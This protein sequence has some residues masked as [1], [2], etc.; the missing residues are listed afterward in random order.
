[1]CTQVWIDPAAYC[2]RVRKSIWTLHLL[3]FSKWY[4]KPDSLLLHISNCWKNDQFSRARF[5]RWEFPLRNWTLCVLLSQVPKA[6]GKVE[7]NVILLSTCDLQLLSLCVPHPHL[8]LRIR[9]ACRV[10]CFYVDV[11]LKI[12]ENLDNKVYIRRRHQVLGRCVSWQYDNSDHFGIL[13]EIGTLGTIQ[14]SNWTTLLVTR[15][16]KLCSL[17]TIFTR[18]F[19]FRLSEGILILVV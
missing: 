17:G 18:K 14:C 9:S 12:L 3:Y 2:F 10:E 13:F 8:M 1:M 19:S 16:I 6:P 7:K 5:F 15:K 4:E 11:T